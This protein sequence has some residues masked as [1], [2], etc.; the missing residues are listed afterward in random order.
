[1]HL[2]LKPLSVEIE[3]RSGMFGATESKKQPLSFSG[4][5]GASHSRYYTKAHAHH[6]LLQGPEAGSREQCKSII[7]TCAQREIEPRY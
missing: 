2:G 7:K 3:R 4:E 1:M 5:Q 6:A